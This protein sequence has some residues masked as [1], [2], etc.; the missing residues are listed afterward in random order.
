V[1]PGTQSGQR[2]R[3]RERGVPSARDGRRG[4]LVVE[5]RLVLPRLLDDFPK[6]QVAVDVARQAPGV[7]VLLEQ[8]ER[9]VQGRQWREL[10]QTWDLNKS[11]LEGR[12]SAEQFVPDVVAWR[13]RRP[14]GRD[15]AHLPLRRESSRVPARS[16]LWG[17]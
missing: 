17:C 6:A 10:V 1:P 13:S 12:K 14:C 15:A 4:D 9:E 3:L 5:V 8:L 11:L 2:F 7:V 16:G